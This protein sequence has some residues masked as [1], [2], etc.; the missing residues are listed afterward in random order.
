MDFTFG[1]N[2]SNSIQQEQEKKSKRKF[3]VVMVGDG[4]TGKTTFCLRHQTGEFQRKYEATI[5]VYVLKLE[6][7]TNYGKFEFEVWDTAGQEKFAQKILLNK[8]NIKN[9]V[10]IL[11]HHLFFFS[12]ISKKKILHYDLQKN[13]KIRKTENKTKEIF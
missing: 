13:R 8:F 6:F 2:Q 9:K 7:F 4:G 1:D 3:K 5:G 11:F 12:S 10:N